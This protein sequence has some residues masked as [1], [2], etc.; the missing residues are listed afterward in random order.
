MQFKELDK[1][2]NYL[3]VDRMS[4]Q[5][6]KI[7]LDREEW[8]NENKAYGIIVDGD[9]VSSC[10]II[11]IKDT[12]MYEDFK[13]L[14]AEDLNNNKEHHVLFNLMSTKKGF[15]LKLIKEVQSHLNTDLM[16]ISDKDALIKYYKSIG[17]EVKGITKNFTLLRLQLK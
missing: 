14:T 6:F 13:D 12:S 5:C 7:P 11:V 10:Q 1:M 17:F 16:L 2:S 15:G 8:Y 4:I 9:L 3:E